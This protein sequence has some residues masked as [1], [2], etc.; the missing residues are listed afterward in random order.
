M[1]LKLFNREIIP[2]PTEIKPSVVM[3]LQPLASEREKES[4]DQSDLLKTDDSKCYLI[5]YDSSCQK[6]L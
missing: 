3:C 6:S 5:I 1:I 4:K 2:T